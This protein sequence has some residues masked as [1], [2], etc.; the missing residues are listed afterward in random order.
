ML[1]INN[2]SDKLIVVVHEIYGINQHMVDLCELLSEENFDIICPDLLEQEIPFDYSQ[3]EKAYQIF[4]DNV[5]FSNG[6][7]KIKSIL[8]DIKDEYSKIFIIGF[9]VGATVAWL[10]C[11]EEY[12]DGIVGYYGSRI[13]DYVNINPNCPV[14]LFFPNEEKSFNVNELVSTI[15]KPNI[16]ARICRGEHGFSDPYSSKYNEELA[17]NTFRETLSF[18]KNN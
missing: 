3:E 16:D 14:L 1:K 11:E 6:L 2:K 15:D 10:C 4:M 7:N 5:G 18:L 13:R 17:Q 12:V 9:S 8:L